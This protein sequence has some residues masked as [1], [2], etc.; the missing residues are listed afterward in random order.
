[1]SEEIS[2]PLIDAMMLLEMIL[3]PSYGY[4]ADQMTW[5]AHSLVQQAWQR[6]TGR[7]ETALPAATNEL[8]AKIHADSAIKNAMLKR[9]MP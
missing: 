3:E 8:L 6:S 5:A 1:M 7:E 9:R 4:P 2:N